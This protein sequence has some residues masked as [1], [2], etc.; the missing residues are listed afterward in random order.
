MVQTNLRGRDFISVHDFSIEEINT[1]LD[2]A[3]ELKLESSR[4]QSHEL[5]KGKT[6][7]MIFDKP[8]TRTR[9]SFEAGM[10]QLGGHA[11][12]LSAENI[13]AGTGGGQTTE[14][15]K[16]TARVI[17]RYADG[18]SMRMSDHSV[19]LEVAKYAN[20]PVIN[21]SSWYEHPCQG[22]ADTMVIREKKGK[23]AGLKCVLTWGYRGPKK[24]AWAKGPMTMNTMV[25]MA[26]KVGMDVVVACPKGYEL[27]EQI[28]S[29]AR[30][31]ASITGSTIEVMNDQDEAAE[32][33]DAIKEMNWAPVQCK[34]LPETEVPHIK[35]PEK[36]KSW[37]VDDQL[38][39][40]AKKDVIFLQALPTVRGEEVTEEV[41]EG[42]HSVV[43]D[44]AENRLHG[45]KA[46]MALTMR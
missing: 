16:D 14:P 29:W 37:I 11:Q 15:W 5:L 26:A 36:Y 28:M 17:S 1:I 43:W 38:V 35:N 21:M 19:I 9:V 42:P 24:G 3:F 22:L 40:R 41:L 18:I 7:A 8:S 2:T 13:W 6:L 25:Q 46:V 45:Q 44:E 32:G 34:G 23:Y 12:F 30:Q 27:E 20:I 33:A 10:S 39:D 4:G 31:D